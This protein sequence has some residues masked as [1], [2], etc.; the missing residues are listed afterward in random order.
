MTMKTL[1]I[2]VLLIAAMLVPQMS[3]AQAALSSTTLSAAVTMPPGTGG[4]SNISTTGIPN[5]YIQVASTTGMIAHKTMIFVDYELMDVIGI[6]GTNLLV[7]RGAEGTRATSHNSGATAYYST[8]TAG[9][10]LI[11]TNASQTSYAFI[12]YDPVGS[13]LATQQLILPQ[14]NIK[15]GNR[16]NCENGTWMVDNGMAV[17]GPGECSGAVSGNSTGTNGI[18]GV[19]TSSNLQQVYQDQTSVTGT[20]THYYQC[21]LNSLLSGI[22][23]PSKQ[24]AILDVTWYYSVQTTTLGTQATVLASGTING[25]LAF[26]KVAYVT[27]ATSETP[28]VAGTARAD[29]GSIVLNPTAANFN[30]ATSGTASFYSEQ[31]TP[32][33]PVFLTTDG[34]EY[35]ANLALLNT[36]TS[37]TITQLSGIRVHYAYVPDVTAPMTR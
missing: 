11:P 34:T 4:G 24:I 18:S 20:N 6:Q 5:Q 33:V 9:P 1:K 10:F 17:I 23:S 36:A 37:A 25:T 3:H 31:V 7:V 16:W 15:T 26:S 8:G 29:S 19:I 13:C 28:T 30:I 22:A 32:G 14:I 12:A 27:P 35:F 2:A 21:N